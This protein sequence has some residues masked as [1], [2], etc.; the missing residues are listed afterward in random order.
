MKVLRG[1]K[2][3]EKRIREAF[4]ELRGLVREHC[5]A[6]GGVPIPADLS[7]GIDSVGVVVPTMFGPLWVSGPHCSEFLSVFARFEDPERGADALGSNP[8][9]GKW[10]YHSGSIRQGATPRATF[11]AW[12]LGIDAIRGGA[13]ADVE[14]AFIAE[15]GRIA[16]IHE[17]HEQEKGG[18]CPMI[19][20]RRP[21]AGQLP[22]LPGSF[23]A[24]P[25]VAAVGARARSGVLPGE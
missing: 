13:L 7:I 15:R 11:A 5:I 19:P 22:E 14:S 16:R 25:S 3:S 18:L 1:R 2:P 6:I 4:E 10:N 23:G 17:W 12:C 20:V 9:S 21:I 8:H 24:L